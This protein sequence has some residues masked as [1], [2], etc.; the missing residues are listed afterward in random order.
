MAVSLGHTISCRRE[1]QPE[2]QTSPRGQA[3]T[4]A[5]DAPNVLLISIDTLRPDHL[6]CY[7]Y[8]RPTS[9]RLDQLASEGVLFENA[10][11]STSWTLPAHAALFTSLADSVHGCYDTSRKLPSNLVTLAER[12]AA[13]G[14]KTVGFF[15]GP[16]L[17]PAFGLDQG[18][19]HYENC[20]SYAQAM[21][22]RPIADWGQDTDIMRSSHRDITNPIVYKAVKSWLDLNRDS[23][24]F[25]F[26]HMWD[27]H[28]DFIPPP[29]YDTMFDPNYTGQVTGEDFLFDESINED[30]PQRD[31]AHLIALYDG[32]IRWTDH[33]VGVI[34]DDLKRA[35]LL[36]KTV[37]AVTSDH[38]TEFFEHRQKAHRKTLFDEVIRIPLIVR[39]PWRLMPGARVRHQVRI[40]DIGPTLLELAGL[41]PVQDVMGY[42]LVPLASNQPLAFDNLAISELFSVGRRIRSIR[43]LEWKFTDHRTRDLRWYVELLSDPHER[44]PV[45]DLTTSRGRQISARYDRVLKDLDAHRSRVL[46]ATEPSEIP[47]RVLKQ[48]ET[49][50]YVGS[51]GE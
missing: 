2:G 51:E 16:Y 47:E 37:V 49:L 32:E 17:H 22:G 29:P 23:K 33:H 12:F 45:K 43:T 3:S 41:P 7:G 31:L 1:A 21:E 30:M 26:I 39:C 19:E 48:L 18:F 50:G 14:Y 6:G 28:F 35:G 38:G 27:V 36:D 8:A 25:V 40:V 4:A 11:S 10:I 34:L 44:Q 13:E 24:F 5:P 20:T 9:P 15:S 42:S 46:A